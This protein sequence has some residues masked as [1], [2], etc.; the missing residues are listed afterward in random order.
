L[1]ERT[2]TDGEI[3][4]GTLGR[5]MRC[6]NRIMSGEKSFDVLTGPKVRAFFSTILD[7][8]DSVSVVIDTHAISVAAGRSL[9]KNERKVLERVGTYDI[10]SGLY[11]EAAEILGCLPHQVQSVTWLAWRKMSRKAKQG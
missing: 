11:R 8:T 3:V 2:L 1:A 7:P 4:A 6:A 10:L 9:S 5:N